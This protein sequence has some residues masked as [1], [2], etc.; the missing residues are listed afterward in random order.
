MDPVTLFSLGMAAVNTGMGIAGASAQSA[1]A[2]Q[3]YKDALKYQRVSD[4]YARWSSKI[5]ARIANT[6]SK[7]RYWAELVNYN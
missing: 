2:R 4:K 6:Q 3:Q 7:Y 5:N 1:S